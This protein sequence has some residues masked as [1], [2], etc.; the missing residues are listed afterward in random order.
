[1]IFG[2]LILCLTILSAGEL[3]PAPTILKAN[4]DYSD[5]VKVSDNLFLAVSDRK[6]PSEAGDR[7]MLLNLTGA[8]GVA[9]QPITV[10]N[11][12]DGDNEPNDL[13]ACCQIPGRDNEFL[14]AESGFY[15]GMYGRIFHVTL[16][17]EKPLTPSLTVN[18]VM[19]IYDRELNA[20][21]VS[22]SGDN[23]AGMVCFEAADQ[24]VLAFGERGGESA[25]GTKLGTLVWGELDLDEQQFT[26]WGESPLVNESVLQSRDCAALHLTKMADGSFALLSVAT[27]DPGGN[28]PFYSVVFRAGRFVPGKIEGRYEFERCAALQILARI[29]GHKVEGLAS[30]VSNAPNSDY[31][32]CTD[33]EN[34]GGIWRAI[35]I[36]H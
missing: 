7:V 14:L 29:D 26:R 25:D 24:L 6:A 2:K 13:E 23:V 3:A 19:R 12:C 32:I 27:Q 31:S 9:V 1:M 15:H 21:Q 11:W 16:D 33:D 5:L 28:G 36:D 10:E 22:Y 8:D 20:D 34:L 17:L 4:S 35:L 18:G 30:P